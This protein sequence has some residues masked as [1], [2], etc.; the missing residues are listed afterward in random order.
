MKVSDLIVRREADPDLL[1]VTRTTH[2]AIIVREP[3]SF[4]GKQFEDPPFST[5]LC[6]VLLR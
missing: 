6:L 3:S 5:A 1:G 2:N 4:L